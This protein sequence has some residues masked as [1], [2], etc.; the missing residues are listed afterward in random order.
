ML[1]LII[2]FVVGYSFGYWWRGIMVLYNLSRNPEAV[3]KML[4]QLKQINEAE[5]QQDL[6]AT[7]SKIKQAAPD[8]TELFIEQVNGQYYAYIKET[9]KFIGQAATLAELLENA[10]KRFPNSKFFGTVED[11][12]S[13]KQVA[14]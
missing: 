7:L 6:D 13:T 12:N 10:H 14:Q 5:G 11:D 1:E 3:I 8:A 9:N 2:A 4:E